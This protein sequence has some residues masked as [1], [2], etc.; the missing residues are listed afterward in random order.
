MAGRYHSQ[1]SEPKR[2]GIWLR[3]SAE[4]ITKRDTVEKRSRA[5]ERAAQAHAESEALEH[6]EQRAR[7]YAQAKGWQ[8]I[9][10]YRLGV[11][12]GKSVIGLPE[13]ERM[14]K[15]I[16][17]GHITGLIFSKLARLARNTRELLDFADIFHECGADLISLAESIDTSTPAGRLF[18]TMIAALAQWER[19]EIAERVAASVPVRA[20]LG[21]P[22][23]GAAPF[24]YQ[25]QDRKLVPHPEE[26]PVRRLLY[27][28]FAEHGR[29]KTV[30][31]LLNEAGHRT[32]NGSRFSDT[33]V[34]RLIRDPTAKGE[35][36]ANYTKSLGDKKHWVLKPESEWVL[37]E[38]EPIVP[39]ELWER[40]NHIL[41]GR[42]Q[43][44]RVV[45]KKPVQLF[46]GLTLCACGGKMYVPSNTPKYVC[47]SCR[48]KVPVT[49]LESV[50]HEQLKGF[51]F[52]PHEI[53]S[54]VQESDQT[55][56]EKQELL[57]SLEG[58][59]KRLRGEM[60]KLLRLYIDSKL[61]SDGFDREYRPL[62][63]QARQL[64]SQ[65]PQLQGEVDFLTIQHLSRDQILT[66]ARDIY[67]RWPDLER[68]E[69]RRIIENTVE[70][71]TIGKDDISI[72]LAYF[73]ASLEFMTDRQ[74]GH[75]DSSPPRA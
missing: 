10:V 3:I 33:T 19:E 65:I 34:E 43:R 39:A 22:L 47:Y 28:L 11:V 15:D 74:R 17:R 60:D 58:Q 55:I 25:W 32:R 24:G 40:C 21:K 6:H 36:R 73:P 7:F 45:A 49:D 27:E 69:K 9:E 26:A 71:I 20:R 63:E 2:V 70:Q 41:A 44:G 56:K 23:G 75:T 18:Y 46:A 8:V 35:R 57:A 12:S 37:S 52:S 16:R 54:F 38:V 29:K 5:D 72:E 1:L 50:F 66:E 62:E 68:A 4:D 13:T 51:F 14:L 48:N 42:R 53:M 30:A 67:T 64:E 31:R 61:S 59:H